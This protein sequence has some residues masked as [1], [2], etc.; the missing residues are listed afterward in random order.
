MIK[1][2]GV[3]PYLALILCAVLNYFFRFLLDYM[4]IMIY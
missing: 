2:N 3:M 4:I 1:S